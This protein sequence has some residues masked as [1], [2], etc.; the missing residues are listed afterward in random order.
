MG[1]SLKNPSCLSSAVMGMSVGAGV[2]P[3]SHPGVGSVTVSSCTLKTVN[4]KRIVMR[5]P[6]RI[7]RIAELLVKVWKLAPDLRLGQLMINIDT[8]SSVP[9]LFYLEDD[10]MEIVLQSIYEKQLLVKSKKDK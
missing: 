5:D 2:C 10:Q 4:V 1:N 7:D 3:Q 6:N 8:K 9:D